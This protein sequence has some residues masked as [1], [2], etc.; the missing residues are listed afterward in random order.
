MEFSLD[1]RL[2][3]Q[4]SSG[5]NFALLAMVF[6]LLVSYRDDTIIK[7]LARGENFPSFR[8]RLARQMMILAHKQG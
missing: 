4:L 1:Q 3:S 6:V 5:K 8:V 7:F 2:Y